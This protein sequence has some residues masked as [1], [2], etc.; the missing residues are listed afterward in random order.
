MMETEQQNS[1]L[2]APPRREVFVADL[3]A[4]LRLSDT[5]RLERVYLFDSIERSDIAFTLALVTKRVDEDRLE[6]VAVGERRERGGKPARDF[7]R[8]AQ[9]PEAVLHLILAEFIDRCGV[10]GSS[11]KEIALV[12]GTQT[13]QLETLADVL[14]QIDAEESSEKAHPE[15]A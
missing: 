3:K 5:D 2:E 13:D 11:Y 10:E 1:N 6:M 4:T 12:D 7:I 8:R 15:V 14:D 9:F